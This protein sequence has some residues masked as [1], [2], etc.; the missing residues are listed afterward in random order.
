M[1]NVAIACRAL[2]KSGLVIGS[3]GNASERF[4]HQMMIK[5]SGVACEKVTTPKGVVL[6]DLADGSWHAFGPKPSTDAE[7]HRYLYKHL[8]H[9]NG[10]VHTH[11]PY[12]TA[13]AVAGWAIPCCSTAQ[14]DVFGGDIP[15]S[16]YC[17][18]GGDDI[19]K[20]IARLYNFDVRRRSFLIR[21]HGV[22]AIGETLEEAV[23]AAVMTE[24]FAHVMWL[25][26]RMTGLK[27]VPKAEIDANY[28]RYHTSYGQ[29][30]HS[31]GD[32]EPARSG[33]R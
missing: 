2:A 14:S 18:I 27:V 20:E 15:C 9:V 11:S 16:E 33:D 31:Q 7:A 17:P 32:P 26:G 10:I 28:T 6:V 12:A 3:Q 21:Q 22:F 24:H 29:R 23:N 19:G 5:A 1:M 4:S 25:A 13:F 30:E 8:P